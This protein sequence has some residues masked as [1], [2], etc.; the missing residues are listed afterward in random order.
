MAETEIYRFLTLFFFLQE[1][2]RDTTTDLKTPQKKFLI[3]IF[4]ELYPC[5]QFDLPTMVGW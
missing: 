3:V 5:I 2:H 4:N 1:T